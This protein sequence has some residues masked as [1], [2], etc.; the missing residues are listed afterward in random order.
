MGT[1][2][3]GLGWACTFHVVCVNF[4]CIGHLF[5]GGVLALDSRTAKH[6]LWKS[7][8]SVFSISYQLSP[9]YSIFTTF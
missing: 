2:E 3:L 6:G 7:T 1:R 9:Y 4:V 8:K 5:F